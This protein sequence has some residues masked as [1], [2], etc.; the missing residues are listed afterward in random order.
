MRNLWHYT[1]DLVNN[2]EIVFKRSF[3][4]ADQCEE[5]LDVNNLLIKKKT[6]G[7][8]EFESRP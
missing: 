7:K 8:L 5:V 3:Q 4:N 6:C 1:K 2:P